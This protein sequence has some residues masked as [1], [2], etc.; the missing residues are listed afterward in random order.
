M[1]S[2]ALGNDIVALVTASSGGKLP[3][4]LEN[5]ERVI[6]PAGHIL[7]HSGESVAHVYFPITGILSMGW[8]LEDGSEV[9]TLGIGP[10]GAVHATEGV[11]LERAT[12]SIKAPLP[13]CVVRVPIAEWQR[14]LAED[15]RARNVLARYA[16]CMLARSQQALACRVKHDV[17]SRFC[18]WLLDMHDWCGGRALPIT[19]VTLARLLGVRRTTVTLMALALQDA[20]IISYRRGLIEITDV[21]ALQQASC[22]C[23]KL[24]RLWNESFRA[25]FVV[26]Q[27][28]HH[29]SFV[30]SSADAPPEPLPRSAPCARSTAGSLRG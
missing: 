12:H 11:A 10:D 23:H 22:E 18:H 9:S 3:P 20:G 13:A 25:Q 16:E 17:E 14:L 7:Q 27:T 30:Q 1:S 6:L 26:E 15:H 24:R 29:A 21:Y 8:A 5:A 2:I 19:H 4:L 28:I